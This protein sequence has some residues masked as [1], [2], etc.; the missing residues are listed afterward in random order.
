[1]IGGINIVDKEIGN[2]HKI[3]V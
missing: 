3:I 1:M 2:V